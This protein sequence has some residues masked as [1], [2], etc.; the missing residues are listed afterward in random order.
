MVKK[1]KTF[2]YN[3]FYFIMHYYHFSCQPRTLRRVS[4]EMHKAHTR[5]HV[6]YKILSKKMFQIITFFLQ[7]ICNCIMTFNLGA[8]CPCRCCERV[9]TCRLGKRFWI[10]WTI[11]TADYALAFNFVYSVVGGGGDGGDIFG[12]SFGKTHTFNISHA[13]CC[14]I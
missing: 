2:L 8:N 11:N 10:S 7:F 9:D 6:S 5:L 3:E 14:S 4:S 12:E 13:M 1:N